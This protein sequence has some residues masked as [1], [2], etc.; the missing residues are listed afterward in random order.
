MPKLETPR[1]HGLIADG[2][3]VFGYEFFHFVE[4]EREAVV[5]PDSVRHD[6]RRKAVILK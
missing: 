2:D 6:L 4:A 5:E 3:A 1:P